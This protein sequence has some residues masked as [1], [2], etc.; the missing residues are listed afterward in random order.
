MISEQRHYK[1]LVRLFRYANTC[2]ILIVSQTQMITSANEFCRLRESS[3]RGEYSR[4]AIEEA[5]IEVWREIVSTR[6]DMRVWVVL[7]KTVPLEM[8]E[9]L[10]SAPEVEVRNAVARKR[11]LNEALAVRLAK[12][13]DETVRAALARNPKTPDSAL[14][15]LNLDSSR[16][17]QEAL[18]A[19]KENG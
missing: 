5:P 17:V 16:L 1:T 3:D 19:R 4:A 2:Q 12:D 9:E 18:C 6:P 7:N 10:T 14:E 15:L 13:V 11:T 8:L